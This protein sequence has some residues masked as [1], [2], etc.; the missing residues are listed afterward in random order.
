MTDY[1][2]DKFVNI[3]IEYKILEDKEQIKKEVDFIF[4]QYS[5]PHRK[6][7]T[8]THICKCLDLLDQVMPRKNA[9]FKKH[10]ILA[11]IYHDIVYIVTPEVINS[12]PFVN[13]TMSCNIFKYISTKNYKWNLKKKDIDDI[14]KMILAT[15]HDPKHIPS[16]LLRCMCEFLCDI[17]LHQL[18]CGLNE[19]LINE[20]LI[21][22]EYKHIPDDIFYIERSKILQSFYDKMFLYHH[23][24]FHL[25]FT[26]NAKRNLKYV[27]D[28]QNIFLT[29]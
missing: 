27:L 8:I 20:S 10:M 2:R 21:R 28:R 16:S 11:I 25:K 4:D 3:F 5:E 24:V 17:D 1:L 12:T 22:E 19:F 7:H 14:G 18:G 29:D 6:Y 9:T 15:T 13:E 26:W 23:E